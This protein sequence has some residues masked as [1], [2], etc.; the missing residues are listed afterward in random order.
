[1]LH[2][3]SS[4][5]TGYNQNQIG[6]K[7]YS[8]PAACQKAGHEAEII[9]SSK[10]VQSKQFPLLGVSEHVNVQ[11]GMADLSRGEHVMSGDHGA[12]ECPTGASS[13]NRTSN[14]MVVTGARTHPH[15]D[16]L[17]GSSGDARLGG[18]TRH[19]Y[20]LPPGGDPLESRNDTNLPKSYRSHPAPSMEVEG[21]VVSIRAHLTTGGK[22]PNPQMPSKK[23][24][25]TGP[26]GTGQTSPKMNGH[27]SDSSGRKTMAGLGLGKPGLGQGKPGLGK[28]GL[29]K[30][31]L[32]L[33]K[34]GL[35]L[36]K[37]GLGLGKPG[38]GLASQG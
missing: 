1:M 4:H 28:P 36:G 16:P 6:D 31:G 12:R 22:S 14:D 8:I 19:N 5:S 7:S 20:P 23:P 34:P 21:S 24:G 17:V 11:G 10:V 3:A 30:L 29:G 27:T 9:G 2:H 32:G 13:P 33:G 18:Q 37:P 35:G 25:G 26:G 38:L 15:Y